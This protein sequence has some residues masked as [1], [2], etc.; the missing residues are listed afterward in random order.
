MNECS[1][2]RQI[3]ESL[4]FDGQIESLTDDLRAHLE[5]CEMCRHAVEISQFLHEHYETVANVPLPSAS[6]VW[7]RAELR[8]RREAMRAVERPL[9]IAHAFAAAATIGVAAALLV[10]EFGWFAEHLALA[11]SLFA[12]IAIAPLALYFALSSK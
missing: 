1:R 10:R 2:E 6:L 8:S 11:V 12:L 9:N 7:W 3:L 5:A 4:R